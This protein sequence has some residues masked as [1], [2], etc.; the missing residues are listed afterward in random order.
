MTLSEAATRLR[1]A[2]K[3]VQLTSRAVS[4]A[5]ANL[6]DARDRHNLASQ[7]V[8]EAETLLLNAAVA[9]QGQENGPNVIHVENPF[10][11]GYT[12]KD[13]PQ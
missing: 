4:D 11:G 5:A 1:K 13:L 8:Q 6:T 2:K 9:D 7:E 3:N 10:V 12:T